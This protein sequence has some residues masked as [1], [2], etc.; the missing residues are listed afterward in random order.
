MSAAE[1]KPNIA[2]QTGFPAQN[3]PSDLAI[4]TR[5]DLLL[6]D[7]GL[8]QKQNIN[9]L[10]RRFGFAYELTEYLTARGGKALGLGL[11]KLDL[12][13]TWR[14]WPTLLY[15]ALM[16]S[17]SE[18]RQRIK[19]AL[20]SR[21]R[22]N[23]PGTVLQ[24]IQAIDS[25]AIDEEAYTAWIAHYD[26]L[27]DADRAVMRVASAAGVLPEL[28]VVIRFGPADIDRLGAVVAELQAQLLQDWRALLVLP[29]EV[30]G[31]VTDRRITLTR[32]PS[33]PGAG[34]IVFAEPNVV[35]RP[36]TLFAFAEAARRDPALRLIYADEDRIDGDGKRHAPWFKPRFSPEF[37]RRRAFLGDCVCVAASLVQE[38]ASGDRRVGE[39]APRLADGLEAH[40]VGRVARVLYH[41][42]AA[43]DLPAHRV[44][45]DFPQA[46][47][48]TV[49]IIIP[50]RNH[51]D[52]LATCLDGIWHRTTYPAERVRVIVIDNG[53]DEPASLEYLERLRQRER[54]LVIPDPSPFNY[55][56]LNNVAAAAATADVLV[57]LNN[58]TEMTEPSWLA[59]IAGWAARPEIG[60]VGPKLLYPDQTIQ[61]AGV[62]LGIGGVAGHSFVG[63]PGDA[64]GYLGMAGVTREAAALT[65]AC[66][67][68]RRAVF[69]EVGGFDERLEI[70]FNDT[71]LCCEALRR[72][73]R[74]LYVGEIS[75]LHHES[76]S[77]GYD[78]TPEKLARFRFECSLVRPPYKKF[79]DNDPYYSPN[80]GLE[81][82][83]QP[84]IPRVARIWRGHRR[85]IDPEPRI[86]I[87]SDVHSVGHGVPVVI[88]QHAEYLAAR[89]CT[90][91]IGG[92]M[93]A[94]E[95][96]YPGCIRVYLEGKLEA[97]SFAYEADVDCVIVH[98][99]PY[100]S[101]FRT[102]SDFPR[103]VI[104]D[105]GEP[106]PSWFPEG[107][108]DR[109]NIDIEKQ[110]CY[111]LAELVL[112][113]TATV[114]D[115]IGFARAE[116][117]GLGNSHLASWG[118]GHALRRDAV[119]AA[120]GLEGK[121]VVLNVCRFHKPE[122]LYKGID[123]YVA[124]K[125]RI[126]ADAPA[127][128]EGVA[129]VLCGKGD[130]E[131]QDEMK[132]EGLTVFANVSDH[133]LIDLYVAAD[134]YVNFSKWEGFNLGIAQ[135]LAM[136]L[137]VIASDIPAH[138]QFPIATSDDPAAR[139][140]LLEAA[141]TRR[142][143]RRPV[144][145]QWEPLLEWL[146][147]RIV[148]LCAVP[149]EGAA[150]SD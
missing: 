94:N 120:L 50:T 65:G 52:L 49:D 64:P 63:I 126:A 82:Q 85:L 47:L 133:A 59:T 3:Q 67:A 54:V 35:L 42:I 62:V 17:D 34:W 12:M 13:P 81:R 91:F 93:K 148:S 146:Y 78:D 83:Y 33:L 124:L 131:D 79:F 150:G 136:G 145:M 128:A 44:P 15:R 147:R 118:A 73:Y 66:I 2:A 57:F 144:L 39:W 115:E 121:F 100:F 36:E 37:N 137:D 21:L 117:A 43:P 14:R 96:V 28:L 98:T 101:M 6:A 25:N 22:R 127:L 105:H 23:R 31:G 125:Q 110:F 11:S 4:T 102:M 7:V 58:D 87:L 69:E 89:G 45:S 55:A 132:A 114:K 97:Q 75:V 72:G 139:A 24:P 140:T 104:F 103:R 41:V 112:T 86:L 134:L 10:S 80:L 92:M 71:A 68:V 1:I 27:S 48:P 109:E 111:R 61:H 51:T 18:S 106:P 19:T 149:D 53:S 108:K 113:N 130:D 60:V 56:R 122:R 46:A 129:F 116:V 16:D 84:A 9:W 8:V 119:R 30:A 74:N 76:K 99:M 29:Q 70:A 90:V 123:D 5:R 138:R 40:Q 20:E 88:R 143:E 107:Q 32:Q 38:H 135:A 77:R 26:G 142:V 141:A 95:I